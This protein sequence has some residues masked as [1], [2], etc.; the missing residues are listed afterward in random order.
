MFQG[1]SVYCGCKMNWVAASQV[2]LMQIFVVGKKC[3]HLPTLYNY[4][5]AGYAST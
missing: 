2:G 5:N 4:Y 1:L 3:T